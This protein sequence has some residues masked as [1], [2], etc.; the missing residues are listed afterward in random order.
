VSSELIEKARV[1]LE[2]WQRGDFTM[3][4]AMLDP[5]VE[6]LWWEAGGWDCHGREAVM[7]LLRERYEQGFARGKL[8]LIEAGNE[9]VIA[10]TYP[11]Q[12]GGSECPEETAT[13]IRFRDGLAAHMQQYETRANAEQALHAR[14]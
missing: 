5:K 7:A 14:R 2:A 11:A 3:L 9:T 12:I 6:L 4:E 10:V 13:V 8:D 1:G